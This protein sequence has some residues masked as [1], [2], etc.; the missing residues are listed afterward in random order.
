MSYA[1]LEKT[2]YRLAQLDHAGAML[3]WDQQVMMPSG[4]NDARGRALAELSVLTTEILQNPALADDFARAEQEQTKLN[5]WQLANLKQMKKEW[6]HAT[7]MPKAL[8]E[9][10]SIATN[11]C[12]YAWRTMRA[13][14]NWA[15]FEPMLQKVFDLTKEKAQALNSALGA[16]NGYANDYEAMLDIFDPGT[17]MSRID[18]VFAELKETIPGL[19]QQITEKQNAASPIIQPSAPVAKS[20]QIELAKALM[21][22]LG[23]DFNQGRLDEAAHPFSGGVSDDSRITS[24]YDENNVIEGIMG[25]IHE[26]GHSRYET[27]LPKDWRY[28]PV[29]QA[30]GMGVHESQSL[31]FEMQMG[32]SAPFISAIAPLVQQYAGNDPAYSAENMRKM[33]THVEPGLIRVNADEVTYPLHVILRY[34]LER[35]IILG[36][37]SVKDIPDRWNDAMSRYLG[38]DTRGDYKNG[39]MQDVHWPGGAVGYF[40]SYTLGAMNAA[41]LHDAMLKQIPNAAD[42]IAS[43]ELAPIFDWLGKNIWSQGSL[44]SYDELMINA[45]GEP[46]N[47]SYFID[48]IKNRYLG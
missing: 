39:P 27:G 17:K 23:F 25:V 21:G 32:R 38:L 3:G 15:D 46:L 8:V 40:P 14:N 5:T 37:A 35:D 24:R 33:Y 4:G 11:E 43:F 1:S 41:Q 31:F 29:G 36:S 20:K 7:A 34:E 12:E 6:Q 10:I 18:P 9:A 13:D 16:E 44:N 42:L 26:T 22:A 28:Q 30:M 47:S 48:H 19:L 2:F 45:T